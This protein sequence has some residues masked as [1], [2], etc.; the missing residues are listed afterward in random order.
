M[1]GP[2]DMT[3]HSILNLNKTPHFDYEAVPKT[4]VDDTN[5]NLSTQIT[6]AYK[7]YVDHSHV[8]PSGYQQKDVF[9]YIMHDVNESSA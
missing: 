9:R 2:V 3:D 8:S 1:N 5:S 4:Y 7:Q 6:N